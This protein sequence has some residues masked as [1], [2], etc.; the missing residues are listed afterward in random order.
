MFRNM[1]HLL[2]WN[3]WII[4]RTYTYI[5]PI[6]ACMR[7][8]SIL[9][10][11][12]TYTYILIKAR[13]G[14]CQRVRTHHPRAYTCLQS[15]PSTTTSTHTHKQTKLHKECR[16]ILFDKVPFPWSTIVPTHTLTLHA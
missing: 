11:T 6:H 4:H 2:Y 3:E 8:I 7:I 15:T 10:H 5:H 12:H 9:L 13:T 16:S 14:N 1:L